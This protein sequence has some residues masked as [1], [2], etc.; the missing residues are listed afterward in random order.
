MYGPTGSPA[1]YIRHTWLSQNIYIEQAWPS[2]VGL[3]PASA[4]SC[5]CWLTVE[6]G[7]MAFLSLLVLGFMG[8]LYSESN[9]KVHDGIPTV[10]LSQDR[11]NPG[12][13][14]PGTHYRVKYETVS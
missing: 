4:A 1:N 5:G 8:Q 6:Q 3:T 2:H 7:T 12:P 14:A 9:K 11:Y 10:F 13:S